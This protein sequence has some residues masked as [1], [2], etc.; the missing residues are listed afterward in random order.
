MTERRGKAKQTAGSTYLNPRTRLGPTRTS[1]LQVRAKRRSN[2]AGWWLRQGHPCWDHSKLAV[3]MVGQGNSFSCYGSLHD[4]FDPGAW[5]KVIWFSFLACQ[6]L[7]VMTSCHYFPSCS[8][9]RRL[10]QYSRITSH[11][12]HW[13]G[14]PWQTPGISCL[15]I[16]IHYHL[17]W[18]PCF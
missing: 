14:T 5:S 8:W 4:E 15:M 2:P 12:D 11:P 18:Q 9:K 16:G 6:P 13:I 1:G 7:R 3:H 17:G 10:V